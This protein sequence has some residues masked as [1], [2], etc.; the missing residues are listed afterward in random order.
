MKARSGNRANRHIWPGL[1]LGLVVLLALAQA[2]P[3]RNVQAQ[4]ELTLASFDRTNLDIE[5]LVLLQTA[6]PIPQSGGDVLWSTGRFGNNGTLLDGGTNG[7][8]PMLTEPHLTD[9]PADLGTLGRIRRSSSDISINKLGGINGFSAYLPGTGGDLRIFFQTADGGVTSMPVSTDGTGNWQTERRGIGFVHFLTSG[10]GIETVLNGIGAGETFIFALARRVPAISGAT[11][12]NLGQTSAILDAAIQDGAGQERTVYFRWRAGATGIYITGTARGTTTA[13][14]A[15]TGL[16]PSTEYQA[17]VSLDSDYTDATAVTFTTL[18]PPTISSVTASNLGRTSAILDAAIQ[19][20]AGQERTVYFRWRAGATGIYITGTARG[21]TT[22]TLALTGLTPSTEYQ[23]EV[24]LDS[25]Y[26]DATAVTFTTLTPPT[27][28]SVTASN[29]GRT[30]AILD[31]AIQDGAGQ[32]RTVYFRWRAG[33]TGIYITGTARGTTTATL[34]LTGLTPSTEYQAEV[35][36]ASFYAGS[37]NV[38]FTT[39]ANEPGNEA[40][41][42]PAAPVLTLDARDGVSLT[43]SFTLPKPR[44]TVIQGYQVRYRSA[45][46]EKWH[47][48]GQTINAAAAR[49]FTLSGLQPK[50]EYVVQVSPIPNEGVGEWGSLSVATTATPAMVTYLAFS[51][52][53]SA[54]ATLIWD[55]PDGNGYAITRYSLRY[56][57][58]RSPSPAWR[59]VA[60]ITPA[61][62][63]NYRIPGL[64]SGLAYEAQVQA[65]NSR[66]A[67]PW[68]SA[69]FFETN[70]GLFTN[71]PPR[72]LAATTLAQSQRQVIVN[73]KWEKVVDANDYQ[74]QF[75]TDAVRSIHVTSKT[76]LELTYDIP[77]EDGG[78]IFRLS[79]RARR[80]KK[81][82]ETY[83]PW[84]PSVPLAYFVDRAVAADTVLV[85]EI[86]GNRPVSPGVMEAREGLADAINEVSAISGFEPDTTGILDFLAMLPA[87]LIMGVGIYGGMKFRAVGLAVGVSSVMAVIALFAGSALL[88]LDIIWPML[89]TFGLV[90]VGIHALVQ[91]YDI[92]QPYLIYTVLFL[93]IHAAAVFAQNLAGYSLTGAAD[94]GGSLW[95]GTP[96]DDL[97]AIRK[98]DSYFDLRALFTTLGDTWIGL[99]RAVVFDYEAFRGHSGAALL[100]VSLI[101]VLLSVSSAALIL[102]IIRQLFSTGIFSSAAGLALVV[103]GVGI[104][105]VISSVAGADTGTPRVTIIAEQQGLAVEE[106]RPAAFT[107][108][109][110][111][112]PERPLQVSLTVSQSGSYVKTEDVGG[113]LI[114]IATDGIASYSVPTHEDNATAGSGAVTV[115]LGEGEGYDLREPQQATVIIAPKLIDAYLVSVWPGNQGTPVDEGQPAEFRIASDPSPDGPLT[116][117]LTVSTSGSYVSTSNS[118]AKTVTIPTQ[119]E[120]TYSVPTEMLAGNA[121]GSVTA[122]LLAG[123]GYS[124]VAPTAA[125]VP[126]K[127]ALPIITVAAGATVS[128]GTS[129]RFT[130][131]ANPAPSA[132]LPVRFAVSERGRYLANGE[133]GFKTVTIPSSGSAT[134]SVD[135][136]FDA[137]DDSDG[138]IIVALI[139]DAAHYQLGALGEVETEVLNIES[140]GVSTVTVTS[141]VAELTEGPTFEY[142]FRATPAPV[143]DTTV[144]FTLQQEGNWAPISSFGSKTVTI[145]TS[146]YATYSVNTTPDSVT[147]DHGWIEA[148]ITPAAGVYVVGEPSSVR[149]KMIDDDRN[150]NTGLSTIDVSSSVGVLT[151][152]QTF[153]FRFQATPAPASNTTI[154]FTVTQQGN[155]VSN[156]YLGSKTVTIGTSGYVAYSVSTTDDNVTENSGLIEATIT[157]SAGVYNLGTSS[158][159]VSVLDND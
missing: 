1:A 54:S 44:G 82:T 57:E 6:D 140:S 158:A 69:L 134:Y 13:T 17:E 66:G 25:D 71:N 9:D 38:D 147:E 145:G 84:A 101:R 92:Q 123:S 131:Q 104:A 148:S 2:G 100:F 130:F 73:V 46:E 74:V 128:E 67:G 56:R 37:T 3:A 93:A 33:A 120:A 108:R 80:G 149:V 137:A 34:A 16:T 103:G 5:V 11:A 119:G 141:T 144:R 58:N 110:E 98:L 22:A 68:S 122:T 76:H 50:T 154:R 52:V 116:V 114:S 146:G 63:P 27:I 142:I 135:T 136:A 118:G 87:L 127:P 61:D 90:F 30:S 51:T 43:V 18:T 32:E 117:N 79:V 124:L 150:S 129:A 72:N 81:G 157:E 28:S 133:A 24:S 12:S 102:T 153:E 126:V 42:G 60:S 151:E 96:F 139:E 45:G 70:A 95:A 26:T 64:T 97:L 112:V 53:N 99:F 121:G 7:S 94:Y 47:E 15:L 138:R 75:R 48:Y 125:T 31:A 156:S 78:G 10:S 36:L 21:T 39:L 106:G 29:L 159:L 14:L 49:R 59:D 155:V 85:A 88:G 107:L 86:A 4:S 115:S 40:S 77:P 41:D 105:A 23:A 19:D 111:P 113:K 20:G 55:S 152:G 91:R 62:A 143:R 109:A 8:V 132:D 83:S 65:A 89:G 35:S